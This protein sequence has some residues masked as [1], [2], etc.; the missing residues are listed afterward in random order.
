MR[1][2]SLIRR[3][4]CFLLLALASLFAKAAPLQLP[5]TAIAEDTFLIAT[6]DLTKLDP[7]T[8][9][10]TA[11]AALGEKATD[12]DDLLA[13]YKSHYAKFADQGAELLSIVLSADPDKH[14]G[15][16]PIYYV[17]FKQGADHAAAEKQIRDEEGEK[18]PQPLEITHDGAFMVI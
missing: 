14:P 6:I 17:K 9:E 1:L 4:S 3:I 2:P 16:E 12:V 5:P 15:P 8:L 11:K 10:A 13:I 18:N 7:A